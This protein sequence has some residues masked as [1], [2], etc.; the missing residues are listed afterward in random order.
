MH[1]ELRGDAGAEA[2]PVGRSD[3][4]GI[5]V[6]LVTGLSGAGRGTA[7]KVL[8]DFGVRY[9][10]KAMSAHRTPHAVADWATS[11]HKNG[12]KAIIAAVAG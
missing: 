12:L 2:L 1:E 6:V 7:A 8:E 9:E 5:D 10:A 4:S 3:E 11:A